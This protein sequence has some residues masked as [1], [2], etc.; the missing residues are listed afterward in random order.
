MYLD[1]VVRFPREQVPKSRL[2]FNKFVGWLFGMHANFDVWWS[3]ATMAYFFG[4]Y[5][6]G[7]AVYGRDPLLTCEYAYF[8]SKDQG[9]PVEDTIGMGRRYIYFFYVAFYFVRLC[10][11]ADGDLRPSDWRNCSSKGYHP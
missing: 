4:M 6:N 8:V 2:R 5:V 11:F 9:C 1:V 7:I 3:R 10:G